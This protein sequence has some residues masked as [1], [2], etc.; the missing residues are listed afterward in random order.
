[1][2]TCPFDDMKTFMPQAN[3]ARA[4]GLMGYMATTWYLREQKLQD[5]LVASANAA[6][7]EKATNVN[8]HDATY[9]WRQTGWDAG[10]KEYKDIG[11]TQ[12]R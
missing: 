1:M 8:Y 7:T 9:Y 6:W 5:V 10:V 3:Y 4:H 11:F 2:I 12:K